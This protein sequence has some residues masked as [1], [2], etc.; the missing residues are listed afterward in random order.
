MCKVS[1]V[2]S[3]ISFSKR[4]FEVKY[5]RFFRPKSLCRIYIIFLK[6]PKLSCP[7]PQRSN[8]PPVVVKGRFLFAKNKFVPLLSGNPALKEAISFDRSIS[9]NIGV[10]LEGIVK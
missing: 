5:A 4:R 10:K 6:S 7:T 8:G 1:T 9:V 3:M 2:H